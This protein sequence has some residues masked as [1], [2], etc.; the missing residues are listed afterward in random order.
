M[1]VIFFHII[2]EKDWEFG[3]AQGEIK[4][5]RSTDVLKDKAIEEVLNNFMEENLAS[6]WRLCAKVL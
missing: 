6:V 4:A 2:A 5:L 3:V 1:T